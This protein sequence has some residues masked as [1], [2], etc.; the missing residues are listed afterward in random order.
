MQRMNKINDC[1]NL[2]PI[3]KDY[4]EYQLLERDEEKGKYT[5]KSGMNFITWLWG[6]GKTFFI[7][8]TL[9]H[10]KEPKDYLWERK[11][12]RIDFSPRNLETTTSIYSHFLDTFISELLSEKYDPNLKNEK[13]G[14][15]FEKKNQE[16]RAK[17][18]EK[19]IIEDYENFF[20]ID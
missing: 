11:F 17:K 20:K 1:L 13:E 14:M 7:E 8:E 10:L 2:S 5:I 6:S 16:E 9:K 19:Q 18:I 15:D 4:I 3:I 12:I